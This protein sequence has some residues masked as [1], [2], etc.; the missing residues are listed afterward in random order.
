V[1]GLYHFAMSPA[2]RWIA[3]II[4]FT[5]GVGIIAMPSDTQNP[6][7]VTA[8]AFA[9]FLLICAWVCAVPSRLGG[10]LVSGG[11]SVLSFMLVAFEV[12]MLVN[13][14]ARLRDFKVIDIT[15]VT[16]L[17]GVGTAWYTFAGRLPRWLWIIV[18]K[19]PSDK[20]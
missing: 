8:Y 18:H 11:A 13:E 6:K 12:V 14:P 3:G 10:R 19:W 5:V 1:A 16:L 9:G 2:L 4:T 15:I 7:P 20:T 17:I